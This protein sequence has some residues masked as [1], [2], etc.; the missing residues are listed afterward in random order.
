MDSRSIPI[1]LF[2]EKAL[3]GYL[4]DKNGAG[5]LDSSIF[6]A[7]HRI[8]SFHDE[9]FKNGRG[10]IVNVEFPQTEFEF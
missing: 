7:R 1:H 2:Q 9:L 5:S 10:K 8:G 6:Y 4:R 3:Q